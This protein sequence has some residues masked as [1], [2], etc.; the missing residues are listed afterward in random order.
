MKTHF[1]KSPV[2]TACG[3]D[4]RGETRSKLNVE[5]NLDF[6]NCGACRA[7]L[8]KGVLVNDPEAGTVLFKWP[9]Q[10]GTGMRF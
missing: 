5:M 4:R 1:P 10:T 6:V 3:I 9:D 7:A 8:R 2:R